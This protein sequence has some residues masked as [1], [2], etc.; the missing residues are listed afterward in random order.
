MET[1]LSILKVALFECDETEK[2]NKKINIAD[3]VGK[4]IFNLEE[5]A[6]K[7]EILKSTLEF[8][9]KKKL[10]SKEAEDLSKKKCVNSAVSE[11]FNIDKKGKPII[12]LKLALKKDKDSL[13]DKLLE[14]KDNEN[15]RILSADFANRYVNYKNKA[16]GIIGFIQFKLKTNTKEER[17]LSIIT[18]D[19]M[20]GA[21]SSDPSTA[22]KFLEKAFDQ[23]FRSIIIYPY[24][25]FVTRKTI[26]TSKNLV[27]VHQ[28]KSDPDLFVISSIKSPIN[29][30]RIFEDLYKTMR[31]QTRDLNEI[32]QRLEGDFPEKVSVIIKFKDYSVK[33][34]LKDFIEDFKLINEVS[35]GQGIFI[36]NT[37]V[38]VEVA[39]KNLFGDGYLNYK[40]LNELYEELNEEDSNE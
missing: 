37:L 39:G 17:F 29:P 31:G 20:K 15:F 25:E 18:T 13:F 14:S 3:L 38:D 11:I 6:K 32:L 19:F 12:S 34:K 2:D 35:K 8:N 33:V 27:K 5:D 4:K 16:K 36:K 7:Y 30:Q 24:L 21:L 26:K 28:R 40:S 22:I 10:T 23:N 9:I 1:K